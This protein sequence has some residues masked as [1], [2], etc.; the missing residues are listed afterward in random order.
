MKH[1]KCMGDKNL[2]RGIDDSREGIARYEKVIEYLQ[3]ILDNDV[4]EALEAV[5]TKIQELKDSNEE[6]MK[7]GKDE[8]A[9]ERAN[10]GPNA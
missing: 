4:Q 9:L 10:G 1:I 7:E 3:E 6:S 2:F 8:E 5:K